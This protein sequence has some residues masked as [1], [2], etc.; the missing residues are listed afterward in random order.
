MRRW[1]ANCIRDPVLRQSV[2]D[3]IARVRDE[4][5][6]FDRQQYESYLDSR[7]ADPD[8]EVEPETARTGNDDEV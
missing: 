6:V 7:V 1:W 3:L 2:G 4:D 8:Q 5:F